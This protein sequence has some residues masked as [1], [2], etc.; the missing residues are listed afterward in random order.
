MFNT[1]ETQTTAISARANRSPRARA[2]SRRAGGRAAPVKATTTAA[3][4]TQSAT[5]AS[6]RTATRPASRANGALRGKSIS[7]SMGPGAP[8]LRAHDS[9]R[10]AAPPYLGVFDHDAVSASPEAN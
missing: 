1:T 3:S 2:S 7:G 8:P 6:S 9:A 4:Q 5:R 10:P